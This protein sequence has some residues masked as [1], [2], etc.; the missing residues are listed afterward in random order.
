M[1]RPF[2]QGPTEV[3]PLWEP[4]PFLGGGR[5]VDTKGGSAIWFNPG[6]ADLFMEEEPRACHEWHV[7]AGASPSGTKSPARA[8]EGAFSA[9]PLPAV[10]GTPAVVAGVR[11]GQPFGHPPYDASSSNRGHSARTLPGSAR[12]RAQSVATGHRA[13][14]LHI[15]VI[16]GMCSSSYFSIR[17]PRTSMNDASGWLSSSPT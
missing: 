16:S 11:R 10:F 13:R 2:L 4:C 3:P 6:M 1:D 8:R 5:V 17:T 9:P 14:Y 15:A 12:Q 7:C